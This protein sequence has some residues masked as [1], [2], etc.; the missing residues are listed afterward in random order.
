MTSQINPPLI[1]IEMM[2]KFTDEQQEVI[3]CEEKNLQLVQA[4]DS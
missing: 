1:K 4:V 2:M 3:T